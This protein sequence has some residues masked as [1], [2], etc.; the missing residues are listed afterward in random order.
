MWHTLRG[1]VLGLLVSLSASGCAVWEHPPPGR[2]NAARPAIETVALDVVVARVP[3]GDTVVNGELWNEVDEQPLPTELR[4]LLA[5]NGLRAG[6]IGTRLPVALERLLKMSDQPPDE[7][8]V[9]QV[10]DFENE[11]IVR[12]RMVRIVSGRRTNI[13]C[14]GENS[15]HAELPV[16]VREADGG[17]R[18][19]TY[20]Q[21]MGLLAAHALLE[22][23]GRVRLELVPEIEHGDAQR[24]F[25]PGEG[26]MKIEFG[27]PHEK[28]DFLRMPLVLSP[29]QMLIVTGLPDRPGSLGY[30]F[31]MEPGA[32]K[33]Q[34]KLLLIRLAQ[35]QY[36]DLF[37]SD[38]LQDW[39]PQ[40][41]HDPAAVPGAKN[42]DKR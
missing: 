11:P 30:Q 39:P 19:R 3:L 8:Q 40:E 6:V 20:R 21:V 42:N 41:E 15:R 24:R 14:T 7:S 18:G 34:Q 9:K 16:L 2:Q 33:P 27:P 36:D 23:D 38:A 32:Q 29:G 12:H 28:Y 26:M 25:E 22:G 31:F 1:V 13:I 37:T 35:T 4:R 5:A 10:V 17:L